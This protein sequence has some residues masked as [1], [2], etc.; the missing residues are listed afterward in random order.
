Q[1]QQGDQEKYTTYVDD[2]RENTA[3]LTILET[4]KGNNLQKY[5]NL[6]GQDGMLISKDFGLWHQRPAL[7]FFND[8]PTRIEAY[9]TTKLNH[10][11]ELLVDCIFVKQRVISNGITTSRSV[12][13]LNKKIKDEK[14]WDKLVYQNKEIKDLQNIDYSLVEK[15]SH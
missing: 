1:T 14:E 3:V 7:I 9:L 12:C 6:I 15:S 8:S 13:G 4:Q 2:K 11:S 5:S 10:Y